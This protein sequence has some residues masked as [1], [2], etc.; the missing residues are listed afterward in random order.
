MTLSIAIEST[1]KDFHGDDAPKRSGP[2]KGPLFRF[3]VGSACCHDLLAL[4]HR[5]VIS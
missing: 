2:T 5:S 1:S 3:K 4:T